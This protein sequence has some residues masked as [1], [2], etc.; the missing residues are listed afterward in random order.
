VMWKLVWKRAVNLLEQARV[1]KAQNEVFQPPCIANTAR[2]TS[3]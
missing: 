1:G 3:L 2:V